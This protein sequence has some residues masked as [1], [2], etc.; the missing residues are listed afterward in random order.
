MSF[1]FSCN[2]NLWG[3]INI[4]VNESFSIS[5][6]FVNYLNVLLTVSLGYID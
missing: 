6:K 4:K 3:Q 5:G 2:I 1:L